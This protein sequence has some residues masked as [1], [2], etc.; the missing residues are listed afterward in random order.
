[1]KTWGAVVVTS[2]GSLTGRKLMDDSSLFSCFEIN[3]EGGEGVKF[4]LVS[5]SSD[6]K[7]I[8]D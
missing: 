6:R 8:K 7:K 3:G 2:T 4:T 1:M 5:G